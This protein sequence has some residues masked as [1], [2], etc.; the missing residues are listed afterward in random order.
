MP[1]IDK[2][3][4]TPQKKDEGFTLVE[5]LVTWAFDSGCRGQCR[6]DTW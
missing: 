6:P 1:H 4:E 3:Q 2:I 5:V